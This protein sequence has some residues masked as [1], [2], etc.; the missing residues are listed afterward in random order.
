IA[1]R[2][3]GTIMGP[4]YF[5]LIVGAIALGLWS[6]DGVPAFHAGDLR[7]LFDNAEVDFLPDTMHFSLLPLLI[8]LWLGKLGSVV[9]ERVTTSVKVIYFS[10]FYMRITHSEEIIPEIRDELD[11]Y[12]RMEAEDPEPV[13]DP[14]SA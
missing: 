3:V 4:V 13:A 10:I 1:A 7:D 12:L 14:S 9:L 5:L 8:A 2:A 6:G 11:A